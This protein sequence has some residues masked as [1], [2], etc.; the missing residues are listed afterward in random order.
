VLLER[1]SQAVGSMADDPGIL[2]IALPADPRSAADAR[3]AV[4]D[5]CRSHQVPEGLAQMGVLV[6]SELVTNVVLHA[7][8]PMIV[9]AEYENST[10]TVAATD[11]G[12]ALPALQGPRPHERGWPRDR[13][14]RPAGRHLGPD[15]DRPREG[16]VGH[17][18][19]AMPS[20]NGSG[21][22]HP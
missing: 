10:L 20:G 3:H 12:A 13:H 5:Y 11:G 7:S 19:L 8:T 17:A 4:A 15:P 2:E 21:G 18:S 16:H 1:L 6:I 14:H 22:R 9:W